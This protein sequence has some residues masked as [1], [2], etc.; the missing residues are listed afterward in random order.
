MIDLYRNKQT[1]ELFDRHELL[2]FSM[3]TDGPNFD[4][5]GITQDIMD[6]FN[7]EPVETIPFDTQ[8]TKY[9]YC[10]PMEVVQIDG[11][12]FRRTTICEHTTEE[13]RAMVDRNQL[14]ALRSQRD[15]LLFAT[16]WSQLSDVSDAVKAKYATYRQQLRDI[17]SVA[18]FPDNFEWPTKPE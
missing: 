2:S 5:F 11:K 17:T 18:G 6:F 15:A 9:Q 8:L 1:G 12:W 14:S 13:G 10:G 7:V 3:R 16:D 4:P